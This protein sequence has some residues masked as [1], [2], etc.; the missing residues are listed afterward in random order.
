[1]RERFF[2]PFGKETKEA[3]EKVLTNIR[4]A[5]PESSG[6]KEISAGIELHS[7]GWHAYRVHEHN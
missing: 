5:H 4:L 7:D 6:W 2:S 3:A 1:M